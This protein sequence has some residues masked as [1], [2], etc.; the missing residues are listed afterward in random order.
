[1]EKIRL[2]S[3]HSEKKLIYVRETP[4]F[5]FF[6][7]KPSSLNYEEFK[8]IRDR[9]EN[10]YNR[11]ILPFYFEKNQ[12]LL[13][14]IISK[15]SK[16]NFN[17]IFFSFEH[18]REGREYLIEK[19]ND[20]IIASNFGMFSHGKRRRRRKFNTDEE[21]RIARILKNRR[22]AE[23]SRQR[24]IQKMKDLEIFAASFEEREKKLREEIQY[25]GRQNAKQEVELMLLNE[26]LNKNNG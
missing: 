8:I 24:R 15:N 12:N 25:L 3:R 19:P 13:K 4:F 7:E 6:W 22:T 26:R 14:N 9:K 10:V 16:N 5:E 20:S 23:E 17:F 2:N 11:P 21:R 1:M 18:S